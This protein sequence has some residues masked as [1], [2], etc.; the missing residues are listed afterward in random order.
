MP[1]EEINGIK[2]EVH[3]AINSLEFFKLSKWVKIRS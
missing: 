1:D 2:I 3:S